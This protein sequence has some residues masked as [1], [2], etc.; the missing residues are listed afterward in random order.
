MPGG[1]CT[2]KQKE[3]VMSRIVMT[4]CLP[5]PKIRKWAAKVVQKHRDKSKYTRKQKHRA[6]ETGGLMF[7]RASGNLSRRSARGYR[8]PFEF[9]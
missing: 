7:F 1:Y 2:K 3:E 4:L 5:E 9:S 6:I 8:L